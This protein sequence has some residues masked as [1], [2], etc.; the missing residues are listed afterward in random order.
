MYITDVV[1]LPRFII[2]CGIYNRFPSLCAPYGRTFAVVGGE[3]AMRKGM[4]ALKEAL[5]LEDAPQLLEALPFGGACTFAA[6]DRLADT[7]RPLAPD[8][9]VGMGGGKA[10]DT[11]KGVADALGIPLVSMPTLV[12]NCAPITALSVVYR[13]DGPFDQFR[14]YD[15]PPALT[16]VDLTIAADA[17]AAYLRAGMGDTLAKHLESTFAAR[18]DVLGEEMDHMSQIGVALSSTCYDPI[19]LCGRRALDEAERGEAGPA[20]ELCARSIIIS[21]GLVSL[22]ANDSYNCA[23]AH[24]SVT[25]CSFSRKSRKTACT[26]IWSPTARW[27]S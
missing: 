15:A 26:A 25:A 17:P 27:F 24:A 20:M 12:S 9:L 22:M 19:M 5:T 8:F 4:P 1:T 16:I 3:T 14:F 13:E 10:I 21:A 6:I 2:G 7:L 11:A 23:L 18:G